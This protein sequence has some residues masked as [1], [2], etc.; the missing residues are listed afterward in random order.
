MDGD[1]AGHPASV[2][3]EAA[4]AYG[5]RIHYIGW[6]VFYWLRRRWI[7]LA[8]AVYAGNNRWD[9]YGKHYRD[10]EQLEPQHN[11]DCSGAIASRQRPPQYFDL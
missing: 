5:D 9:L 6:R 10:L 1:V 11:H 4:A 2:E 3:A 8:P 7:V